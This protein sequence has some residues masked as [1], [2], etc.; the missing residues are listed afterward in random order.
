MENFYVPEQK[1]PFYPDPMFYAEPIDEDVDIPDADNITVIRRLTPAV[2]N[3]NKVESTRYAH[4]KFPDHVKKVTIPHK[5]RIIDKEDIHCNIGY[6]GR[7]HKQQDVIVGCKN[8]AFFERP[9]KYTMDVMVA[10][11]FKEFV[12]EDIFE[13]ME[14]VRLDYIEVLNKINGLRLIHTFDSTVELYWSNLYYSMNKNLSNPEAWYTAWWEEH[15]G[16]VNKFLE[17]FR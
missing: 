17:P 2:I 7:N 12:S 10:I 15:P 1:D 14:P 3:L 6:F 11:P 4:D 9:Y 16:R 13:N 8:I 5:C